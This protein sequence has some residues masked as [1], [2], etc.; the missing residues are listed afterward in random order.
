M[1]FVLKIVAGAVAGGALGALFGHVKVCSTQG[2]NARGSRLAGMIAG[3]VFGAALA[4]YLA[5]AS[6]G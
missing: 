2:C 6:G 1:L 4:Y 3:A 5:A